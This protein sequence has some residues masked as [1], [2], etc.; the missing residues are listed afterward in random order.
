MLY[1][2]MALRGVEVVGRDGAR[3]GSLVDGYA[4]TDTDVIETLIV[5][6]AHAGGPVRLVPAGTVKEYDTGRRVL[7]VDLTPV[8][9]AGLEAAEEG[10]PVMLPNPDSTSGGV[11]HVITGVVGFMVHA[12]DGT[13]GQAADFLVDSQGLVIRYLVVDTRDWLPGADK[14]IPTVWVES[15]DWKRGRMFLKITEAKVKTCQRASAGSHLLD[16]Y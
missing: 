2:A 14:L 3:L 15:V 1:S 4:N 5:D 6:T 7:T 11:L 16:R 9:A 8:Q 12:V 13:V 10:I